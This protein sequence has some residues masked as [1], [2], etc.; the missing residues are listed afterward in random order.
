MQ[1]MQLWE[2]I[3][4]GHFSP[5]SYL[6]KCINWTLLLSNKTHCSVTRP[7]KLYRFLSTNSVY[8]R[9]GNW[10]NFVISFLFET[11]SEFLS[12]SERVE[13]NRTC[14]HEAQSRNAFP[15]D[16]SCVFSRY[17]LLQIIVIR[18]WKWSTYYKMTGRCFNMETSLVNRRQQVVCI[19]TL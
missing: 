11:S 8:H 18:I 14:L 5:T 10:H 7:E 13:V 1:H 4:W 2:M 3:E 17:T 6:V 9:L 19:S 15:V 16:K 12:L